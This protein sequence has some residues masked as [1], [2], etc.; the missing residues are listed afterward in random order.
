MHFKLRQ[1]CTYFK[2]NYASQTLIKIIMKLH[3]GQLINERAN[4]RKRNRDF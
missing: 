2:L 4:E 3:E 1:A